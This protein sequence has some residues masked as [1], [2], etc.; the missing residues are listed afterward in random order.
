MVIYKVLHPRDGID[1]QWVMKKKK[2][3]KKSN[4]KLVHSIKK[5]KE[6]LITAASNS[7]GNIS[8]D[9]KTAKTRK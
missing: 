4:K 9:R 7:I 3:E 2:K 8:T 5:I 6:R 1:W